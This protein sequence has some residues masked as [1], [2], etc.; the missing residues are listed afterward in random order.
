MRAVHFGAGSIGRGFIGFLLNRAGFELTFI[1]VN[2]AVIEQIVARGQY[3]VREI[4]TD[5]IHTVAGCTAID[6]RRDAAAAIRAIAQADIVTTAVGAGLLGAIAPILA[7][8]IQARS[9]FAPLLAVMACENGIDASDTLRAKVAESGI[10]AGL[11]ATRAT[12]ANTGV[13]RIVPGQ[14]AESLDVS[15]E[16]YFEWIIDRTPFGGTEPDIPGAQFVDDL[17]P[18][19]ERKLFTANTAHAALAYH[20]SQ[21]GA[22]TIVQAL[23]MPEVRAEVDAALAATSALLVQKHGFDEKT[24]AAYADRVLARFGNPALTDTCRRTGR[25]PLR[26]LSRFERIIGPAA[27]LTERDGDA[28]ALVRLYVAALEFREPSDTQSVSMQELRASLNGVEFIRRVTGIDA[29][30]PL[31]PQLLDATR[32]LAVKI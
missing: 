4:G 3:E 23:S 11:L 21:L 22:E 28:A 6:S 18:F 14:S 19:V 24:H 30:H 17:A 13:D 12:F 31:H 26:K 32:T 7:K 8:G 27:Q 20:G 2:A 15:V 10:G 25:E 16:P 1:D 5:R 9:K 29:G